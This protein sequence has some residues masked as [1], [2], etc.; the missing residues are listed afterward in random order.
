MKR[1]IFIGTGAL[2]GAIGSLVYPA[3]AVTPSVLVG[4]TNASPTTPSGGTDLGGGGS[5]SS[6]ERTLT[7]DAV[8]TPY[9]PVQVS[10]VVNGTQITAVN[11]QQVPGGRN[12]R[13]TDYAIP[14]LTQET[15]DAQSANISVASGASYTSMG[16]IQ[17]LQSALSQM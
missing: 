5:T 10:L 6:G 12:Q 16:F 4:D 1:G 9:G 15:L 7:G 13:F 8:Q 11:M 3:G 17:S 2:V 14:I